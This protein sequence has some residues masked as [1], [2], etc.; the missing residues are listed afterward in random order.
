M[1]KNKGSKLLFL[2]K[3]ELFKLSTLLIKNNILRNYTTD[4]M[5]SQI[6]WQF[7]RCGTRPVSLGQ[8]QPIDISVKL[9]LLVVH[10]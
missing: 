3:L 6:S 10:L 8:E 2:K 1:K 5:I 7:R 9:H 4:Q